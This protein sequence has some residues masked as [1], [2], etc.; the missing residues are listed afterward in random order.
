[1]TD[2]GPQDG[3]EAAGA[4]DYPEPPNAQVGTIWVKNA[5]KTSIW[6]GTEWE[7]YE[8][9]SPWPGSDDPDPFGFIRG[10]S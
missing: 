5:Y 6:N 10:S 8:D 9:A 1:M 3:P 7:D 2:A 4:T